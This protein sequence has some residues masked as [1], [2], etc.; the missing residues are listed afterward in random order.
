MKECHR[1]SIER[2]CDRLLMVTIQ[3]EPVDMV[4]IQM[5]MSTSMHAEEEADQM[6]EEIGEVL[7]R[8]KGTNHLII[9]GDW[10][11][12]VG[13]GDDDIYIGYWEVWTRS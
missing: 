2:F 1:I 6:F 8:V 10:N 4:V 3:A 11:A 13:E 9:L 7:N 5:Y 12:V